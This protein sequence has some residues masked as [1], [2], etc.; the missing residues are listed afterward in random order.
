MKIAT[1]VTCF[2]RVNTTLACLRRLFAQQMPEG[3][4]LDVWLVD[5]ESPDMTGE[6]VKAAYPQVNVIKGTGDLYWTK[7]MRL[8]WDKA[9]ESCDYDFYLWLNDDVMLADKA[10]WSMLTDAEFLAG[11]QVHD[12]VMVGAFTDSE[13]TSS[14]VSYSAGDERGVDI[15]PDGNGPIRAYGYFGGNFVLVPRGVF[16]KVGPICKLYHHGGGDFDYARML[17]AKHIPFYV[18]SNICGW[19]RKSDKK[20]VRLK[21]VSLFKRLKLLWSPTGYHIGN[22]VIYHFRHDGIFRAIL[23]ACHII[24]IVV[25]AIEPKKKFA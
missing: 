15:I 17:T 14:K 23:S 6:R 4:S 10:L 5:D 19:C 16:M 2:N 8:A 13:D 9:C 18:C 25:F 22:S 24:F 7:G 21:G 3:Y 20:V 12:M 1:L 11:Q